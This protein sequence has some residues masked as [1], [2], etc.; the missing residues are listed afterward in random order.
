MKTFK[1]SLSPA[2]S[3][4]VFGVAGASVHPC[5][6]ELVSRDEATTH[7]LGCGNLGSK[8]RN[9]DG[10]SDRT[11]RENSHLPVMSR[12]AYLHHKDHCQHLLH[13]CPFV[14]PVSIFLKGRQKIQTRRTSKH[15]VDE[16]KSFSSTRHLLRLRF[17]FFS[18][19]QC[20]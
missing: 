15:L 5:K 17:Q 16:P 4:D 12:M 13:L 9:S 2:G 19:F 1:D 3:S 8:G 10:F 11:G 14:E 20:L 18:H 7:N 6:L